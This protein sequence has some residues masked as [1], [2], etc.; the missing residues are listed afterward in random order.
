MDYESI[1]QEAK[2]LAQQAA[3]ECN[4]VL[5]TE[6]QRGF[7]CGF[8]WIHCNN[9][10]SPFARFLKSIGGHKG[11][12]KGVDLWYSHVH[13]VPTQ[14]IGV[15]IAACN[16]AVAYLQAQGIEGLSVGTRFD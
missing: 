5:G 15:H 10:R 16:A 11:Y 2:N 14:S 13:S 3:V 12:P 9:G 8:A 1:W 7:D 4:E 6:S